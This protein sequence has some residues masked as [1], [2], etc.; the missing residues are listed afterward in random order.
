MTLIPP[1]LVE[2]GVS[3]VRRGKKQE[4]GARERPKARGMTLSRPR[5][6]EASGKVGL[7]NV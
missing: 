5:G 1:I 6:V 2:K 4:L 7:K 3:Q